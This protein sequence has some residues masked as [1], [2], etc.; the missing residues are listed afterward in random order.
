MFKILI[1]EEE[2]GFHVQKNLAPFSLRSRLGS[3]GRGRGPRSIYRGG[4]KGGIAAG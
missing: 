1:F 3:D 4:V 2:R